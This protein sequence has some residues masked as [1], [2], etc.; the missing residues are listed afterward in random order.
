MILSL[1]DLHKHIFSSKRLLTAQYV[2]LAVRYRA[3]ELHAQ[4]VIAKAQTD[5]IG[6]CM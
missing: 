2:A 3:A 5:E 6:D 4:E 1:R